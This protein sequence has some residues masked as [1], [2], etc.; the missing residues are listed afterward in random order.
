MRAAWRCVGLSMA[1]SIAACGGDADEPGEPVGTASE[2]VVVC[3]DGEQRPGIDVSYYQGNINWNAVAQ[4]G[5]EFAI[6]RVNHG[7]FMDPEFD[8]NWAAIRQVGLV[9]GAYQYFDA[10]GDPVA[11]ATTL[12]NKVGML[13]PGDLP[14]VIDVESTDGQGPTAIA[15][16][17]RTWLDMV[18][19]ALGRKPIIYTG[20]YFWNDNVGTDEFNDHPLWIAHYTSNCPNLP[21]A[22][23]RWTMWQYTS[24]GSVAGIGGNVDRNRF[25]GPIEALHDLAANGYR[26]S[27]V[28]LEY[29][30]TLVSGASGEVR[31]VVK[32]EGART[33]G[34]ATKLGTTEPRDR[35]STFAS[36]DWADAHRVVSMPADVASG[37]MVELVFDITA[38]DEIGEHVEHFNLVEEGVAWFSDIQ[39]GGGPDDDAIALAI[40]VEPGP[41]TSGTGAGAGSTGAGAGGPAPA[42][43]DSDLGLHGRVSCS[44][45]SRQAPRYP[46]P[47]LAALFVIAGVASRRR[48]S[49]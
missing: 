47:A 25:N 4:D 5:I 24:S 44:A 31:L 20:S 40:T 1:L 28:S 41:G 39:P 23:G 27:V 15:N 21:T 42:G 6:T 35:P 49:S 2:P 9:R 43:A 13:E 32:N 14:P 38:P 22:W 16:N 46:G 11:Q 45:T 3:A 48:R 36:A 26:A 33:W 12:I 8:D 34:A 19:G 37:E 10:G 7:G 18:E 29:P 30:E 17:V